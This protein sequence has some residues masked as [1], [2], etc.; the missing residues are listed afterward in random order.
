M[1]LLSEIVSTPEFKARFDKVVSVSCSDAA[2]MDM[3]KGTVPEDRREASSKA[4]Y[5]YSF[6][7][8]STILGIDIKIGPRR[9]TTL[10]PMRC[11]STSR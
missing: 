6:E 9:S 1:R 8:I 11:L 4:G 2:L 10:Q 3:I 7:E 5:I